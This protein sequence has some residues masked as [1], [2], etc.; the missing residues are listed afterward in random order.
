M[1]KCIKIII[2]IVLVTAFGI[3]LFQ[4]R[5]SSDWKKVSPF[6]DV[7]FEAGK[8]IAEYE[9]TSYEVSSIEGI[10]SSQLIKASN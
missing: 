5:H 3:S 9:G 8:I 2:L 6:T 10:S 7:K 1:K 4:S